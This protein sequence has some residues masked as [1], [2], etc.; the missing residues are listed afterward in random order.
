MA[1]VTGRQLLRK[2]LAAL[3]KEVKKDLQASMTAS[4]HEL[5]GKIRTAAP[6]DEGNL[7]ASVRVEE[8][9]RGGI[10]A[11]VKAGGPLTTRPV[12]QGQS[13]TYDYA[14]AQ[15]LGTQDMLAQPFFFP[16]YRRQKRKIRTKASKAVRAAVERVKK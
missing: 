1:K 10:G 12:R 6:K 11:I 15:E 13:A 16:S 8:F 7:A 9:N 2:T 14:L 4:A 5:A 3:P